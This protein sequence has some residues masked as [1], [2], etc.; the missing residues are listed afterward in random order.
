MS[1]EWANENMELVLDMVL[2][3]GL[4]AVVNSFVTC[5]VWGDFMVNRTRFS[6]L[7][8]FVI[9]LQSLSGGV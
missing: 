1:C 8:I 7:A 6:K 9:I 4:M 3:A 5:I 2:A